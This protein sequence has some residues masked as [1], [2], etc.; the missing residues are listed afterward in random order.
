VAVLPLDFQS[1]GASWAVW[2]DFGKLWAQLVRW[3][4]P[5]TSGAVGTAGGVAREG[6]ATTV[7]RPLLDALATATGGRVDPTPEDV[8]RARDGRAH[9]TRRLDGWLLPLVMALVCADVA[10]R[11]RASY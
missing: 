3:G 10:L 9:E 5:R 2:R 7:N 4:V 11:R 6:R 8:L 1:G